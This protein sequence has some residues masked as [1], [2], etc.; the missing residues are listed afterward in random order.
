M[1][2]KSVIAGLYTAP[3]RYDLHCE[4]F[5]ERVLL[6]RQG[7]RAALEGYAQEFAD[8]LARHCRM[9]PMNWFNFYDFWAPPAGEPEVPR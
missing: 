8:R 3:D 4:P 1:K 2:I 9:A 6:P 7:R 5:A